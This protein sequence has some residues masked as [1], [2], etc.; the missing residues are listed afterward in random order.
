MRDMMDITFR[1]LGVAGIE[2]G[3][4]SRRIVI[5]P[6]VT[7]IPF[8]KLWF[9]KVKPNAA[10]VGKWLPQCDTVLVSHAHVDHLLDVPEVVRQTGADVFGSPNTCRLIKVCGSPIKKVHAIN[11][12]ADFRSGPFSIRSFAQQPHA[13]VG[14]YGMQPLREDLKPPLRAR[15]YS[16]DFGMCYLIEVDGLRLLSEAC[17]DPREAGKVDVLFTIP[18]WGRPD[19]VQKRYQSILDACQPRLVIPIHCD[20]MWLPLDRPARGQLVP[21]GRIIPPLTRMDRGQFKNL[22]EAIRPGTHVFLPE[23]MKTYELVEIL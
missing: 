19:D 16:M 5:D 18:F 3:C 11:P 12:G 22:V 4:T 13:S 8:R 2:I 14:G 23:R 15:D 10:L 1:W 7:R 20:D 17:Q 6:Y 21:T 9:G